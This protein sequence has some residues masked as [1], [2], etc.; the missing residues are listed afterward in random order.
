MLGKLIDIV[1]GGIAVGGDLVKFVEDALPKD[2][3]SRIASH[4]AFNLEPVGDVDFDKLNSLGFDVDYPITH[5]GDS[6][7]SIK[8]GTTFDG[9]FGV[10]DWESS[11]G[12]GNGGVSTS[13]FTKGEWA[14]EGDDFVDDYDH[15]IGWL[16]EKYPDVGDDEI[17]SL[18][19][20]VMEDNVL[21]GR[22]SPLRDYGFKDYAE[23]EWEAQRLRG[24]YASDRGY[25]AVAMKDESGTSYLIPSGA[26]ER[27]DVAG[28]RHLDD[29]DVRDDIY[30]KDDQGQIVD[31]MALAPAAVGMG[32]LG[33]A[34]YT[35]EQNA[36][37]AGQLIS[38]GVEDLGSI[39]PD[40]FPRLQRAGDFL[41]QYS[42]TPIGPLLEGTSDYLRNF[43]T[44]RSAWD[45]YKDAFGA[46]T[47]FM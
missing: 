26:W 12:T 1:N 16:K 20:L 13:F 38:S 23:M 41:D 45:R 10:P 6:V 32:A 27:G 4:K 40:E 24:Q 30:A 34:L 5:Q 29:F 47:D 15:A 36:A 46:Y 22:D 3:A 14:G 9:L 42:E 17:S 25:S 7:S 11:Y 8:N 43:G 21:G 19:E 37:M 28:F 2:T 35:P 44:Q 33:G 31:K 18:Y 39:T